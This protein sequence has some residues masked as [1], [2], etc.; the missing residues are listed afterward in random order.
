MP[1]YLVDVRE[2][3]YRVRPTRTYTPEASIPCSPEMVCQEAAPIWLPFADVNHR[4][5]TVMGHYSLNVRTGRL[6][7]EPAGE[8]LV[9][10]VAVFAKTHR[11]GARML[12]QY[13]V[14]GGWHARSR[15]S[16]FEE[17]LTASI[18]FAK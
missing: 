12:F 7:G 5:F 8:R 16:W 18:D 2:L 13:P 6:E 11:R 10:I 3:F 1:L 9:S 15:A 17:Q 4:T 14:N